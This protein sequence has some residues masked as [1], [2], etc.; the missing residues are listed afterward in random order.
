MTH[1]GGDLPGCPVAPDH[2]PVPAVPPDGVEV[3]DAGDV[4]DGSTVADEASGTGRQA[5]SE[6]AVDQP[7]R[8]SLGARAMRGMAVS[9]A[10]QLGRAVIQFGSVAVLARLLSPSDYGLVAMVL[11]VIGIGEILREAGLSS[12]AIQAPSLSAEERDNLFW[13]NTGLG[14]VL[15]AALALGAPLVAMA[16]GRPELTDL[17]RVLALTFVLNGA[18]AQ[19]RAGF[20]RAM[21]F[22]TLVSID[23]TSQISG[24]VVAIALAASGAGMWALAAQQITAAAVMLVM[25]SLRAGWFPRPWHRGVGVKRFLEFGGHLAASQLIGYAANNADNLVIGIRLGPSPLGLYSRAFQ[26]LMQSYNMAREPLSRVAIPVFARLQ[27]EQERYDQLVVRA[28]LM[29]GYLVAGALSLVVG[30]ADPAVLVLLGERWSAA[31]PILAA[32]AASAVFM[33]LAFVGYWVYVSRGLTADLMRYTMFE[34]AV[35]VTCVVVG[36]HWGVLGVAVGYMC[37]PALCWPVSIWW[38]STRTRLPVR[39]LYVGAGRVLV[40]CALA[41]AVSRAVVIA[42]AGWW[43]ILQLVAGT[44]AALAAVGAVVAAVPRLRRDVRDIRSTLALI[45]K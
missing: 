39:A 2:A 34:A 32:L 4:T 36:S 11:V 3:A 26:L 45:R 23:L 28:Q 41:A 12:A 38:L 21:R 18:T 10:G 19:F 22:S 37:A 29:L 33:T 13:V 15:G 35:K 43:P 5:T 30:M 44:L 16:Y 31:G 20:T 40:V 7:A 25:S 14:L 8:G 27:E 1:P 17:A 9:A 42:T 24:I 6:S